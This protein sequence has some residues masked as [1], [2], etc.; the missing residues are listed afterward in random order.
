MSVISLVYGLC[1]LFFGWIWYLRNLFP[2]FEIWLGEKAPPDARNIYDYL[3]HLRHTTGLLR[4]TEHIFDYVGFGATSLSVDR[5]SEVIAFHS[6][7]SLRS[8]QKHHTLH[9]TT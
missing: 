9:G 1:D 6:S 3:R 8:R 2:T 5:A 4:L 7:R